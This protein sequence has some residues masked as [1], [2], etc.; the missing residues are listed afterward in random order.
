MIASAG[1]PKTVPRF[2]AQ[3]FQMNSIYFLAQ[4]GGGILDSAKQT[5]TDFGFEWPLF[6]SQCISFA[7]V[8]F[9]LQKFAYKPIINILEERRQRIAEGL[10]NADKIKQQLAETELRYQEI[11]TK[12]NT[13]AQRMIDEARQ[14][15]SAVAERRTQQAISEAEGIIA[16]AREAT[17]LEHDRMLSELKREVGRLVLDTTSKVTGKVLNDDDQRRIS[18]ETARQ[19]AA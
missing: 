17:S 7:I 18:E 5:A 14:S 11:L 1:S 19:V 9:L 2:S 4:A 6:L 13:E 3:F 15:A 8:A 12:A 10:A 16:K